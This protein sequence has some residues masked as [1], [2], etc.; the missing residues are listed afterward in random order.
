MKRSRLT[1]LSMIIYVCL[2]QADPSLP[3]NCH[4]IELT[5]VGFPAA[6]CE[7]P[8]VRINDLQFFNGRLYIGYGDAVINTGPTDILAFDFNDGTFKKEFTVDEEG[9][10]TYKIVDSLL[11]IPGIDAT[12]DWHFG[13]MY[14]LE[15]GAWK[16]HRSIPNGIHV[17]DLESYNEKLYAS[18]GTFGNI[19]DSIECYFGALFASA[20]T[21]KT[22]ELAYA[23]PSDNQS[24]FRITALIAYNDILY[25]FP[26]AYT[27]MD[28]TTIPE[29]FHVGLTTKPF[30]EGK[31][32]IVLEDILGTNDVVTFD[33]TRWSYQ[34]ILPVKNLCYVSKPFVFD[35]KLILPTLTGEYID[36][37]QENKHCVAQA[38][39]KLYA[40]DG[41]Q[42]KEIKIHYDRILDV[43]TKTEYMF[44]LIQN[45]DLYYIVQTSDMKKWTY[46]VLPPV[47]DDP[48]S[49]EYV[50][51]T[52]FVGTESGNLFASQEIIPVK[53]F[54]EIDQCVPDRIH[55]E[56]KL[57]SDGHY[58]WITITDC[59]DRTDFGR[60]DA[61]VK[62]G[63]IIKITTENITRFSILLPAYHM[64]FLH[65]TTLIINDQVVYERMTD[66]ISELVCTLT[67]QE[68]EHV[69]K[70]EPG[71]R[72]AP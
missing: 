31:Y 41:S 38:E 9:I 32:L 24:I 30:A 50:D 6:G 35:G 20:D 66:S 71:I 59:A 68:S 27:G 28:T 33:G 25:A 7:H 67:E 61:E 16:K 22:W 5:S 36:Y 19:G 60:V 34:D 37:L 3:K 69:W 47:I 58:Y 49:L 8:A 52:F 29:K 64:D 48:R 65:E 70:I 4:L 10:Y 44:L 14:V 62:Y 63:N 26:F 54:S 53:D 17:N 1:V 15:N 46:Y 56:A 42:T 2:T 45:N 40:F 72:A 12:D 43:V 55:A 11:M 23:T 57:P 51:N 39:Q 13:N 21:G 18:T